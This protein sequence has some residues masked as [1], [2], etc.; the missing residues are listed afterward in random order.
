MHEIFKRLQDWAGSDV[1]LPPHVWIDEAFKLLNFVHEE[2]NRLA[3]LKSQVA[4]EKWNYRQTHKTSDADAET[5]K[6]TLLVYNEMEKVEANLKLL[7]DYIQLAKKR[8]TLAD[9][10]IKY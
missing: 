6:K 2:S 1:A 3:D 7:N 8:A 10:E 4:R 5:Y 9:T